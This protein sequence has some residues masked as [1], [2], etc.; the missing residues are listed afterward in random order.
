MSKTTLKTFC[1]ECGDEI[2]FV[3]YV[4]PDSERFNAEKHFCKKIS[5]IQASQNYTKDLRKQDYKLNNL[6]IFESNC[7]Q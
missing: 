6:C 3:C 1:A 4:D 5:C 2:T 7:C